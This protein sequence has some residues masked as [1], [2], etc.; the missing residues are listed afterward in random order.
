MPASKTNAS[1]PREEMFKVII[2]GNTEVGKTSLM[3]RFADN[4]FSDQHLTTIGVDFKVCRVAVGDSIVKLQ[5][6]D[7]AGQDRFRTITS[8]YYRGAHGVIVVYD[9][10][11][12]KSFHNVDSWLQE[13]DAHNSELYKIIVGN[14]SDMPDQRVVSTEDGQQL[15][16]RLGTR[17]FETS[18]K[19]NANV[20][21]MFRYMAEQLLE[22][23]LETKVSPAIE[24]RLPTDDK[25]SKK[26]KK[27]C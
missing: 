12:L 27:C 1:G 2:I 13:L 10:T 21:E 18:A 8:T 24:V 26:H 25:K 4:A 22:K 14:K 17:L 6:W 19:N 20:E 9:L 16:E 7:T 15:A 3:L 11:C 5:L 23:K